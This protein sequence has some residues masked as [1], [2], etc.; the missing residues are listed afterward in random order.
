MH[1]F[2]YFRVLSQMMSFRLFLFLL[3]NSGYGLI[4]QN[5]CLDNS[6]NGNKV[7]R[8]QSV[9]TG[10]SSFTIEFIIK[11]STYS[12]NIIG[13]NTMTILDL[14]NTGNNSD[15]LTLRMEA[16]NKL[17][18]LVNGNYVLKGDGQVAD[19]NW[20]HVAVVYDSG[21]ARPYRIYLD[22]SLD[23]FGTGPKINL[24][25]GNS[26][27]IFNDLNLIEEVEGILDE[28]RIFNHARSDSAIIAD[29]NR[30]YCDVSGKGLLAYYKFNEGFPGQDNRSIV[31]IVDYSGNANHCSIT[32]F[33]L[34]GNYNNYK[35]S[36]DIIV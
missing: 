5:V 23:T 34:R 30:E 15:R 36:H 8:T 20:H 28:F 6:W 12:D 31:S 22:G 19:M 18:V 11:T 27:T 16:F 10:S 4:A 25:S 14:N 2:A 26:M 35:Y 24:S 1:Y 9:L 32:G 33:S 21:N 17:T 13:G 29:M 7:H 3:L